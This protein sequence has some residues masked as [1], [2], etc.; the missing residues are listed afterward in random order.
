MSCDDYSRMQVCFCTGRDD[1]VLYDSSL[2][3]GCC[4]RM[5]NAV[6]RLG[7]VPHSSLER[8]RWTA[9]P[10]GAW[11]CLREGTEIS[12]VE[13]LARRLRGLGSKSRAWSLESGVCL[14][15][16]DEFSGCVAK[17]LSYFMG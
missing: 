3:L 13:G 12:H 7:A 6:D 14:R 1:E 16:F 17:A 4:S 8:P 15:T 9:V 10:D 5:R 11:P 2:R